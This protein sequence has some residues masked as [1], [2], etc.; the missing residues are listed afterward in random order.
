MPWKWIS[1]GLAAAKV[2]RWRGALVSPPHSPSCASVSPTGSRGVE[3]LLTHV[4]S[5]IGPGW[6]L[7]GCCGRAGWQGL[8]GLLWLVAVGGGP[9]MSPAMKAW[10]RAEPAVGIP[11][12]SLVGDTGTSPRFQVQACST[13]PDSVQGRFYLPFCYVL[14]PPLPPAMLGGFWGEREIWGKLEGGWGNVTAAHAPLG[15]QTGLLSP[16]VPSA[17]REDC[18]PQAAEP[19]SAP[20]GSLTLKGGREADGG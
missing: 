8:L 16:A 15:A 10:G 11:S 19:G 4:G 14:T 6:G 13:H 18:Y 12:L 17:G 1:K 20:P 5:S 2:W 7:G 9:H 3:S